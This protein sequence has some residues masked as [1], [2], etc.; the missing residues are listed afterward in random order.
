MYLLNTRHH[1]KNRK[2]DIDDKIEANS[3]Y[4]PS[5]LEANDGEGLTAMLELY[6]LRDC[7]LIPE[8]KF[9]NGQVGIIFGV[10]EHFRNFQSATRNNIITNEFGK[11]EIENNYDFYTYQKCKLTPEFI[12]MSEPKVRAYQQAI[13]KALEPF[14]DIQKEKNIRLELIEKTLKESASKKKVKDEPRP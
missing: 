8:E 2:D 14:L 7:G 12:K 4:R 6:T 10:C 1:Q 13:E 3:P 9:K 11:P 5:G